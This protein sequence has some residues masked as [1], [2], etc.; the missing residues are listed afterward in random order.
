M[1]P[2]KLAI[3]R[4]RKIDR[5]RRFQERR[6]DLPGKPNLQQMLHMGDRFETIEYMRMRMHAATLLQS[7]LISF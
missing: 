4:L 3:H 5:I 7:G 1:T 6:G 2:R